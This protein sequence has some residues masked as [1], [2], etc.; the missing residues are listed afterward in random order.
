MF[1]FFKNEHV[2]TNLINSFNELSDSVEW[3]YNEKYLKE[4][5][6]IASK[7]GSVFASA[8]VRIYKENM[9]SADAK[10]LGLEL[11]C[12]EIKMKRDE[13]LEIY[14]EASSPVKAFL[15]FISLSPKLVFEHYS[16]KYDKDLFNAEAF[17]LYL[18]TQLVKPDVE[19]LFG[20]FSI[21]DCLCDANNC[22]NLMTTFDLA[23]VKTIELFWSTIEMQMNYGK[24]SGKTVSSFDR[25]V[26]IM[27]HIAPVWT[28]LKISS[29]TSTDA[30]I[31]SIEATPVKTP[32]ST[33]DIV[34]AYKGNYSVVPATYPEASGIAFGLVSNF[35]NF[36][37]LSAQRK[38]QVSNFLLNNR[39]A[40][41]SIL[42]DSAK[43]ISDSISTSTAGLGSTDFSRYGTSADLVK[44]TAATLQSS[45]S[46]IKNADMITKINYIVNCYIPLINKFKS[47]L[48]NN[49]EKYSHV[50]ANIN[51]GIQILGGGI[52]DDTEAAPSIVTETVPVV[53]APTPVAPVQVSVKT[54]A[55]DA[56][57][58]ESIYS[59]YGGVEEIVPIKTE[60]MS[61]EQMINEITSL[62]RNFNSEYENIYRQLIKNIENIQLPSIYKETINKLYPYCKVFNDIAIKNPK[63]TIWLSGL[64]G[65]KNRNGIYRQVVHETI[66][67]LKKSGYS[68]FNE[69]ISTLDRLEKL[70]ISTAEKAKEIRL[71]FIRSPK[72]SP[73]KLLIAGKKVKI[74]CNL[75]L[76]DFNNFD[77]AVNA[78]YWQVRNNSSESTIMNNKEEIK[79]YFDRMKNREEIIK[80]Q[81]S[82]VDTEIQFKSQYIED[83]S[84]RSIWQQISKLINDQLL[85]CCLY[86]NN[87][88]E[89]QLTKQKMDSVQFKN[90]SKQEV[91]KIEHAFLMF[92][93]AKMSNRYKEEFKLLNKYMKKNENIFTIASQI[94]KIISASK[95]IEFI[96]T[97]YKE[98]HIFDES[99]NWDQFNNMMLTFMVHNSISL[100]F[101]YTLPDV[102]SEDV[103]SL[104]EMKIQSIPSYLMSIAQFIAI[105]FY[106][107]FTLVEKVY[108]VLN[109]INIKYNHDANFKWKDMNGERINAAV[110]DDTTNTNAILT[111]LNAKLAAAHLSALTAE[112]TGTE[113][114][115]KGF[116][117]FYGI[118]G[119]AN[120]PFKALNIVNNS[121]GISFLSSVNDSSIVKFRN[122]NIII[123][124]VFDSLFVNIINLFDK[125][126]SMRYSGTLPLPMNVNHM[127]KGGNVF[128]TDEFH[129]ISNAEVI[130]EAVPFYI[131]GL[132]ICEYYIRELNK[133]QADPTTLSQRLKISELS[134]LYP[135]AE[136]F[137]PKYN[138]QIR[139]LSNHQLTTCIAVLNDIWNQTTGSS[140][141]KLSASI[142]MLLNELN[143]SLFITDGIQNSLIENGYASMDTFAASAIN[144]V[145]KVLKVIEKIYKSSMIGGFDYVNPEE[146]QIGFERMLNKAYKR[147][148]DI[149][150][151]MRMNE[152]RTLLT[153]DEE[154]QTNM[155]EYYKFMDLIVSP[156]VICYESYRSIFSLFTSVHANIKRNSGNELEM[157]LKNLLIKKDDSIISMWDLIQENYDESVVFKYLTINPYVQ[158]W[159]TLLYN[160]MLL[161]Y[162]KTG[163]II[164]PQFWFVMDKSTY[165]TNSKLSCKLPEKMVWNGSLT[166]MKQLYP[167]I[168]AKTMGDYFEYVIREFSTSVDQCLHLFMSYPGMKDKTITAIENN[169]HDE[170]KAEKILNNKSVK[171][172]HDIFKR[173]E[174]KKSDL[175]IYP[176]YQIG[177]SV[178]AYVHGDEVLPGITMN[179]EG[180]SEIHLEGTNNGV[181]RFNLAEHVGQSYVDGI[182]DSRKGNNAVVQYTDGELNAVYRNGWFDYAIYVI[183]KSNNDFVIPYKLA[184]MIKS[185]QVLTSIAKEMLSTMG[186]VWG[187]NAIKA[188][189][190][191]Y[192]N[193]ITMN[194]M[195]RSCGEYNKQIT[196]YIQY[197]QETINNI[198]AIIPF[199]L[200]TLEAAKNSINSSVMY[201]GI[202]VIDEI[203]ATI[204]VISKFYNDISTSVTPI[205]Y[206]QEGVTKYGKDHPL[207]E[208]IKYINEPIYRIGSYSAIE[209]ANKYKFSSISS[210]TYPEFKNA[211]RFEWIKEYSKNVFT[212]PVFVQNFRVIIENMA[213]QTWNSIIA[214]T[215]KPA[216][217]N[218]E[219]F[220][221]EDADSFLIRMILSFPMLAG[222]TH[223]TDYQYAID[224]LFNELNLGSK[225]P[226]SNIINAPNIM[227]GGDV[228]TEFKNKLDQFINLMKTRSPSYCNHA[229]LLAVGA[230]WEAFSNGVPHTGPNNPNL[231]YNGTRIHSDGNVDLTRLRVHLG[232]GVYFTHFDDV[233]LIPCEARANETGGAYEP[234]LMHFRTIWEEYTAKYQIN[235]AKAFRIPPRTRRAVGHGAPVAVDDAVGYEEDRAHPVTNAIRRDLLAIMV[236]KSGINFRSNIKPE[237]VRAIAVP[238]KEFLGHK[239]FYNF[240]AG[241][242]ADKKG[243]ADSDKIQ[244]TYKKISNAINAIIAAT[245]AAADDY[246]GIDDD[247]D[248]TNPDNIGTLID[249]I[250]DAITDVYNGTQ[251]A[252]GNSISKKIN[253][254]LNDATIQNILNACN[255]VTNFIA[256]GSR[257]LKALKNASAEY[258]LNDELATA[259]APADA[260]ESVYFGP[261]IGKARDVDN[262]IISA[263]NLEAVD[264]DANK[265]KG[266]NGVKQ[267]WDHAAHLAPFAADVGGI[268]F[269]KGKVLEELHNLLAS[270]GA[271]AASKDIQ[272]FTMVPIPFDIWTSLSI[273][274]NNF[275]DLQSNEAAAT[276]E[277]FRYWIENDHINIS[278]N[279]KLQDPAVKEFFDKKLNELEEEIAKYPVEIINGLH[280]MAEYKALK[281][282]GKRLNSVHEFITTQ[283]NVSGPNVI[284][285]STTDSINNLRNA[286]NTF[287]SLNNSG[288]FV[289]KTDISANATN[290]LFTAIMSHKKIATGRKYFD[291]VS[292]LEKPLYMYGYRAA[293][294][295]TA[296]D[297][298]AEDDPGINPHGI[299]ALLMDQ[300]NLT[301][302]CRGINDGINVR[303]LLPVM[304]GGTMDDFKT[305]FNPVATKFL[306]ILSSIAPA[307]AVSDFF[308]ANLPE[309]YGKDWI[310]KYLLY[311]LM[312]NA[313]RYVG[314]TMTAGGL[315]KMNFTLY[316]YN[317]GKP[318]ELEVTASQMKEKKIRA[319]YK[320]PAGAGAKARLFT[321]EQW[322]TQIKIAKTRKGLFLTFDSQG[323]DVN[324]LPTD[325]MLLFSAI[326]FN[327][328]LSTPLSNDVTYINNMSK[329]SKYI[330]VLT[331]RNTPGYVSKKEATSIARNIAVENEINQ[332]TVKDQLLVYTQNPAIDI[333]HLMIIDHTNDNLT[334]VDAS[335][336]N[337]KA[338]IQYIIQDPF[339]ST[340]ALA[341]KIDCSNTRTIV[342]PVA[343]GI[344]YVVDHKTVL[345]MSKIHKIDLASGEQFTNS[346]HADN[347]GEISGTT[348]TI[349]VFDAA[350]ADPVATASIW[351]VTDNVSQFDIT[352]LFEKI[353]GQNL[354]LLTDVEQSMVQNYGFLIPKSMNGGFSRIMSSFMNDTIEG[355]KPEEIMRHLYENQPIPYRIFMNLFNA[356][357]TFKTNEPITIFNATI[358]YFHKFNISM[359]SIL[360]QLCYAQILMNSVTLKDSMRRLSDV[361]RLLP[362]ADGKR[363]HYEMARK[364]ISMSI[365]QDN[366]NKVVSLFDEDPDEFEIMFDK[367]TAVSFNKCVRSEYVDD[368]YITKL[369]GTDYKTHFKAM[370]S[371][372]NAPTVNPNYLIDYIKFT[373]SDKFDKLLQ[374]NSSNLMNLMHRLDL[375]C[376]YIDMLVLLLRHTSFYDVEKDTDTSLFGDL[377]NEPFD[378]I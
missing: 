221:I 176:V 316:D 308:K 253:E 93:K 164:V 145:D 209:W 101:G 283:W 127:L 360:N 49:N 226:Q 52:Y 191:S 284:G 350:G 359:S 174:I 311:G 123:K 230:E 5:E 38:R 117:Y 268:P 162:Q 124:S 301:P 354:N 183:A 187:Y 111:D 306:L 92:K 206:L 188:K 294:G 41:N 244:D 66:E 323:I 213:N 218:T 186:K 242:A 257:I 140:N 149:S 340:L 178:P 125:Y 369:V 31:D 281:N 199:V 135:I 347:P 366:A 121:F 234:N 54:N 309:S 147:V 227:Y 53:T 86:V 26:S 159:N 216:L 168:N 335:G 119:N 287:N 74:P 58:F 304:T 322:K 12:E 325:L 312:K 95:Y 70:L 291:P 105:E 267:Q 143:A 357:A 337:P 60:A 157:D 179:G 198:V 64:Y 27:Q 113:V 202:R 314:E 374:I 273:A 23:D 166:V 100:D 96:A 214:A 305:A 247:Q 133:V 87:V 104:S 114:F 193:P 78:L 82:I 137:G 297:N 321:I 32:A 371:I 163:K 229:E 28:Q 107:D 302:I 261:I 303:D 61:P 138:V 2:G 91:I 208:V 184:Q 22:A 132:N 368:D 47:K 153:K 211:D 361:V 57:P 192:L 83:I 46:R 112:F 161:E 207:G 298:I 203:N 358:H 239:E 194:I 238:D 355:N 129:D 72:A 363:Q 293:E 362:S 241:G 256:L 180:T 344:Y 50:L 75:T 152:L 353:I 334:G 200:N 196:D 10:H 300:A 264:G 88:V 99:F 372:Y 182:M 69:A 126:W 120:L 345:D 310:A 318:K 201:H 118:S 333:Q 279:K 220:K 262:T 130:P 332:S 79:K 252:V 171:N 56:L 326:R 285:G 33:D 139:M 266:R 243:T 34:A 102:K 154:L 329:L 289:F 109:S 165:P 131:T 274:L 259:I 249:N 376:T 48:M 59:L 190:G 30:D 7:F 63:T 197:G 286:F 85:K 336:A 295:V 327:H 235:T 236:Y 110:A 232:D 172:I 364:Y 116:G 18:K 307:N 317:T 272:V 25:A 343:D 205:A 81:F 103:Y 290:S 195:T 339:I 51:D 313:V 240:N 265:L 158:E 328:K 76:N 3:S 263:P 67:T 80:Q 4:V 14:K 260:G 212:H 231:Q 42:A 219:V 254:T 155:N 233:R 288:M 217:E 73:E 271:I 367:G 225:V 122:N 250:N 11:D 17:N 9:K 40:F 181:I 377:E 77:M 115:K 144:D 351:K 15:A 148:K 173:L 39:E 177:T 356:I 1:F 204:A 277:S 68:C 8:I 170:F 248:P 71:R 21:A 255:T 352:W 36:N 62:Q 280:E 65:K 142:D 275:T 89:P 84:L 6:E 378:A 20:R 348:L 338:T 19:A 282:I 108:N 94:K 341:S 156:L 13:L 45:Y 97:I 331:G 269:A 245:P 44:N 98:F 222:C 167:H 146:E 128:D 342:A 251:L 43:I 349:H 160:N 90:L 346:Y 106:K 150:A 210:I 169:L 189:D 175:Y 324:P 373:Q 299:P 228:S 151:D 134:V 55:V 215:H 276:P 370:K 278:G 37:K 29:S 258:G 185:D 270:A 16:K 292:G 296:D 35:L 237:I 24:T 330:E 246:D 223:K 224:K 375:Q 365:A 315:T 319:A 136:I 320:K 141:D